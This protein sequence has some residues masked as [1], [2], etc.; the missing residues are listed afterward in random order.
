MAGARITDPQTSHDAAESVQN[1][2]ATQSAILSI[3][4]FAMTDERLVDAYYS[5]VGVGGAPNASP[6]GIRSRRAELAKRGLIK[7]TGDRERLSSG[8]QAILWQVA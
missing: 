7:D 8:R 6:S 5:M 1:I 2:S 4:T 3:L